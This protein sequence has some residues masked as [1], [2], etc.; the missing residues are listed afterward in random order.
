MKRKWNLFFC[1]LF[2][3]SCSSVNKEASENSLLQE[4][5]NKE[6]ET[7]EILKEQKLSLEEAIRLAKERNLELKMKE[8]EKEIASIDK[9]TAFGNFLPKISAFYTRS[10]WEEPLSAQIDLPS[11]LGKFPMIGPLLPKEIH[12]RLLDQNYSVYGMQASMPIFAPATWFLYS[13]RKKGE[14]I[15]SLVFDLT[16]KMITVKV[17]QQYYWILAL[18]SE[19]K[20]LQ[21]SLQSAEQ[22]LH[23]TKIALETQSILDW[24]YQKAEV[25]YKQKKL[26]LEEN[27]RDL[28]IANMN[29]LLTLNLSPFSEIYLEDAN[30]STKKPL[31]NYEEVV[32]QSL[33]HSQALEIQNK[34]IE[35]EKEKVKISLSRFLPIVGLQGFY[36]EHSFSLLTSPHYLFGIL[37]GV[38]SV[39][40]GFQDISAYQK[41]KIEQQ[42]AIIKWEQLMLQTIAETT[43]VYQKLQSSLEEQEIAQGNLKAENGKFYQKE[44]EKKVGMIDELSYLQALQSYEEAR[45]LNAKAEYQSAVL[46]EILDMLMEQGRFVK[47]REGEKNE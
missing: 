23:N 35:V 26:A 39:F 17:I 22:L 43:N 11:S 36:G 31:L 3:T 25:Y 4:L 30:L 14:D 5:Q 16:E 32:Y 41:A 24:Q 9:R 33:L 20:Q 44:M 46:Q 38:F 7:Q 21:A 42:K 10:F 29:L 28:K 47:I 34:M 1:L 19:E 6:K 40:N 45:S 37:G 13:A 15:H 8:L 18:K 12:G 2:L 27:R